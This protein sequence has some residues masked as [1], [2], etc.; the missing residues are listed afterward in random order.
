MQAKLKQ[1]IVKTK[2]SMRVSIV[3]FF[4]KEALKNTSTAIQN[5]ILHPV[6]E[7]LVIGL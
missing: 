6:Q 4:P 7:W 1:K 2:K 3:P 5:L